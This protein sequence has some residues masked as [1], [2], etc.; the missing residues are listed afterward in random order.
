MLCSIDSPRYVLL[1]TQSCVMFITNNVNFITQ[2]C[3]ILII[4]NII[5]LAN[6]V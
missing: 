1:I 5:S 3:E 2:C 6:I 4:K